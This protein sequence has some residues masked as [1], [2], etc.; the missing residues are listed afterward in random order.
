MVISQ[1]IFLPETRSTIPI[2]LFYW[3]DGYQNLLEENNP[4]SN[5]NLILETYGIC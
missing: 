4:Y 1:R 3:G 2:N 5:P